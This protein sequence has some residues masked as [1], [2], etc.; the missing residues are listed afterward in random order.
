MASPLRKRQAGE[1]TWSSPQRGEP[2]AALGANNPIAIAPPAAGQELPPA[3]S[4]LLRARLSR[5]TTTVRRVQVECLKLKADGE[6]GA[7]WID[8][9]GGV[10]AIKASYRFLSSGSLSLDVV[11]P[12]GKYEGFAFFEDNSGR[13]KPRGR[14]PLGATWDYDKGEWVGTTSASR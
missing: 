3:G 4:Y 6:D 12:S 8:S 14:A 13:K 7:T 5:G 1:R 10:V 11:P 2:A 9:T